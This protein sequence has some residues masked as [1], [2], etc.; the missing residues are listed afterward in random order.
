VSQKSSGLSSLATNLLFF[1]FF[2]EISSFSTAGDY[3]VEIITTG[4][5]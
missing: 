3:S 1:P 2:A 5:I 4:L